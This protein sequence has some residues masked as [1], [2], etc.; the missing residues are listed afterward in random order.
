MTLQEESTGTKLRFAC[1]QGESPV[2]RFEGGWKA[3]CAEAVLLPPEGPF[4]HDVLTKIAWG[5]L[6][7]VV[8]RGQGLEVLGYLN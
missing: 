3:V 7:M 2:I 1:V 5:A 8:I 6:G 4:D